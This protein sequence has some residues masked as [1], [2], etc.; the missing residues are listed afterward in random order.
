MIGLALSMSD[1]LDVCFVCVW[2]VV[3]WAFCLRAF[4]FKC[5]FWG[6][7]AIASAWILDPCQGACW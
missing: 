6:L 3:V 5:S 4:K 2:F 7:I 1:F